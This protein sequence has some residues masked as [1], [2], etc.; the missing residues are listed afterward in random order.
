[1]PRVL[2]KKCVA[3]AAASAADAREMPCYVSNAQVRQLRDE[4]KAATP[5]PQVRSRLRRRAEDLQAKRRAYDPRRKSTQQPERLE[6]PHLSQ[7]P[8]YTAQF[9]R[10]G[11]KTRVHA[12]G[13][14]V[15]EG[16]RLVYEADPQH[17]EGVG[18]SRLSQWKRQVAELVNERFGCDI[19][20]VVGQP[21]E[22]CPLCR[23]KNEN[24]KANR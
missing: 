22:L 19:E 12:V 4:G 3:C 17:T 6:V 24:T 10:Y 5:C 1:M 14:Q 11:P 13:V 2:D 20:K 18:G 8:V 9:V 16:N 7:Q 15:F 21:R 23:E